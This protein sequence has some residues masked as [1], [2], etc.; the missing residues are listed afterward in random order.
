MQILHTFKQM[1]CYAKNGDAGLW[2]VFA[3]L[4]LLLLLIVYVMLQPIE[5]FS[6]SGTNIGYLAADS[7][8][9]AGRSAVWDASAK[10]KDGPTSLFLS[11][12]EPVI[13]GSL[14]ERW[15]RAEADIAK[16]LDIVAKCKAG[17]SCPSPAQKLIALSHEG[18][19]RTGRARIGLLNRAVDLAIRPRDDQEQWGVPDH[20]SAP[21]ETLNSM[22]GDCEDYAIVKYAALLS[23]GFPKGSVKIILWRNQMPAEDHAVVGVWVDQQWLILDNRTLTLVSDTDVIR[24]TPKFLLDES[25]VRRFIPSGRSVWSGQSAST[26]QWTETHRIR[27]Q[28]RDLVRSPT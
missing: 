19:D 4:C 23:A 11:E 27:H 22:A 9:P 15:H 2:S 24:V 18:A 28:Y 13:E 10:D 5:I 16:E 3:A 21:F 26:S 12:T 17:G 6:S 20:W 7:Q 1:T 8:A 25:G 14:L